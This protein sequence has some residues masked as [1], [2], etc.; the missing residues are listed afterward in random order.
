MRATQYATVH[1]AFTAVAATY[2]KNDFIL[3]LPE[4]AGIYGISAGA[5]SYAS[6]ASEVER[7][8]EVYRKAGYGHG[9]RIGLLLENRPTYL[10]HWLAFNALGISVVPINAELRSA[11]LSY[12]VGHSEIC[13]AVT[14][15]SRA[16]DLQEAAAREGRSLP[17][18]SPD[19]SAIPR[20]PYAPPHG[21]RVPDARTE[22]ALLYTSGTTGRPKG[23]VLSN[24]YFLYSGEWYNTIGGLISFRPGQERLITPLPLNHMNAFATSTMGMLINGGCVVQ[25]DRFHPK[26]WWQSVRDSGATAL[27]YLG[28]M[29]AMLMGATPSPDDRKH[30]VRFGLGSAV[31]IRQ[32]ATF[33]ERFGFPL[34]EGWA[35]TETGSGGLII[36]NVEPRKIGT[37][38]IGR[39]SPE[40]EVKIVD[41][42]GAEVPP[43]V[44]GEL[45]IRR[46]GPD[47]RFGFYTEYLKDPEATSAAWEGGFFHTG[48][49]LRRDEDGFL[50]FV[51]RKKNVIRRSGENISAVEVETVIRRHPKVREAACAPTPDPVRGDEV[52]ACIL[53]A[54]PLPDSEL[55]ELA[56]EIVSLCLDQLAYYKAPGYVAFVETLPLT[57]TQKVQ[58]AELKVLAQTLPGAERC[59]DTRAMK[60]RQL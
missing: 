14:L 52:L 37:A 60:K 10:V 50:Y 3:V 2:P 36:A 5:V 13:L 41:D 28:V 16:K 15:P 9:H 30:A 25:L 8:S 53:L 29:P 38:T 24:T 44:P 43:N 58:R 45:L 46:A 31:D 33:E 48:D 47:P 49:L 18:V 55:S 21:D 12:L 1:A 17:T 32:H 35:M 26:T 19:D 42:D 39:P 4:T 54:N 7:L 20:A 11:D 23:C 22:C 27:H 56:R 40:I 51:D 57:A 34:L 59:Y 6:V